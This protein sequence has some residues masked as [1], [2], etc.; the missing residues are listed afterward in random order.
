L[1][2]GGGVQSDSEVEW[3]LSFIL[4]DPEGVEIAQRIDATIAKLPG[5]EWFD[6]LN[7]SREEALVKRQQ[8]SRNHTR[9]ASPLATVAESKA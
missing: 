6:R 3:I 8:V 1:P 9:G 4:G 5:M 7:A 2:V